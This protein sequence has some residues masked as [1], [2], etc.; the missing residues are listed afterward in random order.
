MA[1]L[2]ICWDRVR[3]RGRG[4]FSP[5]DLLPKRIKKYTVGWKSTMFNFVIL[6]SCI[7]MINIA[8]TA[9][10]LA[11]HEWFNGTGTLYSGRC[12]R[13]NYLNTVA[14]LVINAMSAILLAGGNFCMQC[15]AAPNR[16]EID[17]AHQRGRTFDVGIPSLTNVFKIHRKRRF[18]WFI[19]GVSSLPLHLW[20]EDRTSQRSL[21]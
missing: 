1:L 14:H 10:V 19:L 7:L 5:D 20:Y 16:D 4:G 9:S 3:S 15:V 13:V 12:S 21:H 2:Q 17:A 6:I 11:R 8:F 18:W